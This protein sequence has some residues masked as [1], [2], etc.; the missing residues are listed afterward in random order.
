MS[1]KPN[2]P[3]SDGIRAN[4]PP[5]PTPTGVLPPGGGTKK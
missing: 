4:V 5:R 2:P 3:P 1:D